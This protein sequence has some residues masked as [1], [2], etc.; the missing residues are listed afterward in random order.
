[1]LS[2]CI[3]CSASACEMSRCFC[4]SAASPSP[5]R[6]CGLGAR[7]SA[8]ALPKQCAAGAGCPTARS[9]AERV[10]RDIRRTTR[11]RHYAEDKIRVVQQG[12]RGENGDVAVCGR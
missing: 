7:N 1:M 5:T 10:A 11:K 8:R 12:L 9:S 2:G 4:P 3:R 6:Q